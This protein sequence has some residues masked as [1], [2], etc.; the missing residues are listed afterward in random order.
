MTDSFDQLKIIL[1]KNGY[2]QIITEL[3]EK[4]IIQ[5]IKD[6]ILSDDLDI[7]KSFDENQQ[8]IYDK[9]YD[10]QWVSIYRIFSEDD[11]RKLYVCIQS[12]L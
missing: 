12:M 9:F 6:D 11:I 1:T 2:G 7:T 8:I 4:Q 10:K 5:M 3:T